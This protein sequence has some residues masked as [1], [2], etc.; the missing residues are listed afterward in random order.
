[1][2]CKDIFRLDDKQELPE[3]MPKM[4]TEAEHVA[5]SGIRFYLIGIGQM[6][7]QGALYIRSL[8]SLNPV[9]PTLQNQ[10]QLPFP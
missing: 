8:G 1:M 10:S 5:R 7:A 4:L 3:P 9:F 6:I 2:I